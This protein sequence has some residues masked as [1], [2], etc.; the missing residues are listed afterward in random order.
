VSG[1]DGIATTWTKLQ[2]AESCTTSQGI[3][4]SLCDP[5]VHYRVQ[6]S[7]FLVTIL[8]QM[9]SVHTTSSYLLKIHFNVMLTSTS[10]S[11]SFRF[12]YQI[13]VWTSL[14]CV[15]HALFT[16]SSFILII[17][18]KDTYYEGLHQRPVPSPIL[19]PNIRLSALFSLSCPLNVRPS[20]TS[21]NCSFA[22]SNIYVFNSRREDQIFGTEW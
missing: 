9:N 12:P 2:E 8:S 10:K 22:Y 7:S 13:F 6:K 20:F 19:D 17:F 5:K 11:Y 16:I 4:G 18:M 21:Q 3:T 15:L 1:S 14:Q